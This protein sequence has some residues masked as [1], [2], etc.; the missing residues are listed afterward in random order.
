MRKALAAI[1]VALAF[2]GTATVAQGSNGPSNKCYGQITAG[3]AATWPWAHD[4]KAAFPPPPGSHG[5]LDPE[6]SAPGLGSRRFVTSKPVFATRATRFTRADGTSARSQGYVRRG[7][8]P[9]TVVVGALP[10]SV[11]QNVTE[12]SRRTE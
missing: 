11:F 7:A 2:V 6:A 5:A 4:D 8:A 3:I 10:S 12:R 1:A 9:T